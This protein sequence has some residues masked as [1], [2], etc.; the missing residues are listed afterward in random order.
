MSVRF[1]VERTGY[2]P[3]AQVAVIEGRVI[4]GTVNAGD[5]LQVA[6]DRAKC[7][8]VKS[9]ALVNKPDPSEGITLSVEKPNFSLD[10][11]NGL[12]LVS[13]E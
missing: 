6:N 10:E 1:I 2:L 7:V 11:L 8:R 5:V 3:S 9:I 4:Q 12:E 13:A